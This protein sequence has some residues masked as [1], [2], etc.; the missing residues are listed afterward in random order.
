MFIQIEIRGQESLVY[1]HM[2]LD[3]FLYDKGNTNFFNKYISTI[4]DQL[5]NHNS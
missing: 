5:N 3:Y 1:L 4:N 2:M